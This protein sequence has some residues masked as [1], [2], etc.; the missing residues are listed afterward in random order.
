MKTLRGI[1]DAQSAEWARFVRTPGHDRGNERFNLPRLL[2]LLPPPG[3]KT[4]DLGCGEGRVG[5]ALIP[6][7]YDVVGVDAS[8]GMVALAAESQE[9]VVADAAALPF[10]DGAFDLVVAFMSL[11]DFD[12]PDAAIRETARVLESGGRFCFCITHPL[13]TA[14]TFRERHVGEPF[15]LDGPYFEERR[16]ELISDRGGIRIDFASLHRPLDAWTRALHESGFALEAL[17]EHPYPR[18]L[19]KDEA[20]ERWARIPLFL[21]VRAVKT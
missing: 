9:A 19:W 15:A 10:D 6:L 3:R 13:N 16:V 7:G 20:A 21:H 1:W 2:D 5:R 4:L 8:P 18:E 12:E 11:M 17:R 14:G